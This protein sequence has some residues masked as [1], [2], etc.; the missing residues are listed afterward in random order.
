MGKSRRG[1]APDGRRPKPRPVDKAKVDAVKAALDF[2][3]KNGEELTAERKAQ[4]MA[5]AGV[6]V[7]VHGE[8]WTDPLVPGTSMVP[9]NELVPLT[10]EQ[11]KAASSQAKGILGAIVAGLHDK[12]PA[13]LD[14]LAEKE[15]KAALKI[16]MDLM[17]FQAPK[18][19]RTEV[20]GELKQKVQLFVAVEP[21]LEDPRSGSPGGEA[22][23]P[24][25]V[26]EQ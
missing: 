9:L 18:L 19:S 23:D 10:E 17:E 15:P 7:P 3:A 12:V 5:A 11:L 16:Y 4:A 24:R 6:P 25:V 14:A 26:S 2:L 21:R 1:Y 13:M 8:S 20:S 22:A